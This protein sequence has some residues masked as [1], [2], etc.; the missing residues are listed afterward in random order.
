MIENGNMRVGGNEMNRKARMKK[1]MVF[2][3]SIAMVLAMSVPAFAAEGGAT[4]VAKI[5]EQTYDTLADAITASKEGD[6]IELIADIDNSVGSA[7]YNNAGLSYDLKKGTVLNGAGHTVSGHVGIN[8]PAAGATVENIN[9]KNIHNNVAVPED[10]CEKYGFDSKIG[11]QSAVYANGLT[12]TAVITGCTFDNIDW[13]AIQ[14]IP[15]KTSTYNTT[16]TIKISNNIFRHTDTSMTQLRYVHVEY[17]EKSPKNIK[18]NEITITDNQFYKSENE[19]P[20]GSINIWRISSGTSTVKLD[21]N[22]VEEK[23]TIYRQP[24]KE[25]FISNAFT[26]YSRQ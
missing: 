1:C 9:F 2:F 12:G 17:T 3:L 19:Y 14:I 8:I 23:S 15:A 11:S 20:T 4:G 25:F 16:A 24:N 10:E 18:A 26:A 21:G 6:E 7:D 13:D 5:G 22:Y